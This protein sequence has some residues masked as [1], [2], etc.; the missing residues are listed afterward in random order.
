MEPV[1][2]QAHSAWPARWWAGKKEAGAELISNQPSMNLTILSPPFLAPCCRLQKCCSSVLPTPLKASFWLKHKPG[3]YALKTP[4]SFS[5]TGFQHSDEILA[6]TK[7]WEQAAVPKDGTQ[8]HGWAILSRD[9]CWKDWT[10][11][12]NVPTTLPIAPA[13]GLISQ[14]PETIPFFF[15]KG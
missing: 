11:L 9:C 4:L 2:H 8:P 12:P 7:Y 3:I 10:F 6:M 1:P 15:S 5:S 13:A 14:G